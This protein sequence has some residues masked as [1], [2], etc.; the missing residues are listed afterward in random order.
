MYT[1]YPR[2]YVDV[3]MQLIWENTI[4][5]DYVTSMQYIVSILTYYCLY[6]VMR[7]IASRRMST[8]LYTGKVFNVYRGTH[9]LRCT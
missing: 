1:T 2:Y 8:Y 7:C 6:A 4:H 5:L 3:V 9:I